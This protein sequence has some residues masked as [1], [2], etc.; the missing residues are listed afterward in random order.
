M[1]VANGFKAGQRSKQQN[2]SPVSAGVGKLPG[3]TVT[4]KKELAELGERMGWKAR[5]LT[6]KE[7]KG[8]MSGQELIWHETFSPAEV[9]K[10]LS[11]AAIGKHSDDAK[12]QVAT[13]RMWAGQA[14]KEESDKAFAAG[15]RFASNYSQF[16]RNTYNSE[17]MVLY[18]AENNLDATK[19]QSYIEAFDVLAPQG[20]LVL[21]P[22]AAG[23]GP[24]ETLSGAA[25][26]QYPRLHLLCQ[27]NK[28]L[29]PQDKLSADDWFKQHPE[30]HETRTPPIILQK[31][32]VAAATA[33][34]FEQAKSGTAEGQ[35][36]R[37]TDMG[38]RD[39]SGYPP[40]SEKFSFKSKVRSM[41]ATEL[42]ERCQL[43]PA[44]KKSLDEME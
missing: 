32:Q 43:D 23:I 12:K 11:F 16:V 33:K 18:M 21:S 10:A 22:K 28:V 39:Y 7:I 6:E 4:N 34:H 40:E 1:Y 8:E 29:K 13:K 24:E 3:K 26:E 15:D 27:P 20:K 25:L 2:D 38:G 41:S 42:A 31:Q 36:V 5:P 37:F 44:F 17:A 35:A 19:V 9:E 30:L 14:T